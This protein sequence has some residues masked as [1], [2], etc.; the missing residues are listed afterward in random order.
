MKVIIAGSRN[1]PQGASTFAF[2]VIDALG[3]DDTVLLRS[4]KF[5]EPG[6]FEK[7]IAAYC[8][9]KDVRFKWAKPQPDEDNPG[10]VSVYVRDMDMVAEADSAL[11]FFSRGDAV[12]GNSGTYHLLEKALDADIKVDAFTVAYDMS[13]GKMIAERLGASDG[14][15]PG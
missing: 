12:S 13:V 2:P 14:R 1:L 15:V 3:E 5:A 6:H 9:Y 10:R 4:P 7:V 8:R 11:L